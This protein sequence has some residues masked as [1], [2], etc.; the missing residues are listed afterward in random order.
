MTVPGIRNFAV[1][2]VAKGSLRDR[3]LRIE[4]R[5]GPFPGP[6]TRFVRGP[7][8]A[9]WY[10]ECLFSRRRALL[11][12]VSVSGRER[13][14]EGVGWGGEGSV[15]AEVCRTLS[16]RRGFSGPVVPFTRPLPLPLPP[17]LSPAEPF[18][19]PTHYNS[20][21]FRDARGMNARDVVLRTV[22]APAPA[23]HYNE[24]VRTRG[25]LPF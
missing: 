16:G 6:F 15:G 23:A 4:L 7:L 12:R 19:Q 11:P 25:R 18:A 14:S 21:T 1:P 5:R 17:I 20:G 9:R 24:G 2:S 8:L 13:A 3:E 22:G 10:K